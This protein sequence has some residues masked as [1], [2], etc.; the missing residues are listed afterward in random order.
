MDG[1]WQ[2]GPLI[3][4]KEWVVIIVSYILTA[5]LLHYL[6]YFPEYKKTQTDIAGN[7]L[8]LFIVVYQL[9]SFI[10]Y[11]PLTW[12]DPMAVLAS[13]GSWKEWTIAW[14][15]GGVYL[16][17]FSRPVKSLF[18]QLAV[19]VFL[20]FLLTEFFY[21]AFYTYTQPATIHS[22]YQMSIAAATF[23]TFT[24]LRKKLTYERLLYLLLLLYSLSMIMMNL[25]SSAKM[26]FIYMPQEPFFGA[27]AIA[28]IGFIRLFMKWGGFTID[29]NE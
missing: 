8:F 4:H 7:V 6:A 18:F 15:A 23:F 25:I 10:F 12:Q 3:I 14:A 28:L 11:F 19:Y 24:F 9:S 29:R 13:P 26:L 17:I 22:F 16:Y 27:A 5:A 2:V 1:I 20:T 21:T